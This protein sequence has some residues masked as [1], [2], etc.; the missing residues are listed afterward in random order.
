MFGCRAAV[1]LFRDCL[2]SKLLGFR[3]C[4]L[5]DLWFRVVDAFRRWTVISGRWCK[6]RH[7]FRSL[8]YIHTSTAT[9]QTAMKK[10]PLQTSCPL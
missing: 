6:A 2:R 4:C 7:S 5:K 9:L 10:V 3:E 8:S 1:L